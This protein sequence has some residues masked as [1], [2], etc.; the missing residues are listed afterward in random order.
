MGSWGYAT[1]LIQACPRFGKQTFDAGASKLEKA[2]DR[3]K[4]G[5]DPGGR[6]AYARPIA[7]VCASQPEPE[8]RNPEEGEESYDIRHRGD[9]GTR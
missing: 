6:G 4:M 2:G 1:L 3:R 7:Q 9:E 5:R 8:S